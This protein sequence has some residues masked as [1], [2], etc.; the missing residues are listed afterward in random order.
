MVSFFFTPIYMF[1]LIFIVSFGTKKGTLSAYASGW[2]VLYSTSLQTLFNYEKSHRPYA[3]ACSK[4]YLYRFQHTALTSRTTV[5]VLAAFWCFFFFFGES[6]LL[7]T[8]NYNTLTDLIPSGFFMF[9]KSHVIFNTFS[10]SAFIGDTVFFFIMFFTS[11]AVGFLLNLRY[12]F[13]YSYTRQTA[14][15]DLVT[16]LVVLYFFPMLFALASTVL[17]L[18]TCRGIV[19]R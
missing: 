3:L 12:S 9:T 2:Y 17:A 19:L 15:V 14:T 6:L 16:T 7:V 18:R 8:F 5:Y 10:S 13:S 4:L 11:A 1:I